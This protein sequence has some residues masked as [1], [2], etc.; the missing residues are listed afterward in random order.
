MANSLEGAIIRAR[1]RPGDAK[2]PVD[3]K[4][5]DQIQSEFHLFL[6][7]DVLYCAIMV[8][9]MPMFSL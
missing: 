5:R 4:L 9:N 7:L 3:I 1:G 8:V 6:A 2:Y